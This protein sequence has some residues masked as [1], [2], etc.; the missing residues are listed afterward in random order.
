MEVR[1]TAHWLGSSV[2]LLEKT[3]KDLILNTFTLIEHDTDVSILSEPSTQFAF[4]HPFRGAVSATV[5]GA[6]TQYQSQ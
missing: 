4:F 2:R 1:R 6:K 5:D 3:E